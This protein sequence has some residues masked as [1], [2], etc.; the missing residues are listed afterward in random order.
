MD[1]LKTGRL[2]LFAAIG[3]F[4]AVLTTLFVP[5]VMVL[6]ALF[7]AVALVTG[8][9]S[10]RTRAAQIGL[11]ISLAALPG[12]AMVSTYYGRESRSSQGR[13]AAPAQRTLTVHFSPNGGC[14]EAIIAQIG[15]AKHSI[16]VQ[17]YSFTSTPI[18]TA[19]RAAHQRGIE[20]QVILDKS[21]QT[22]RYS[23]ATFL[24]NAGIAPQI[25]YDHAIAHNKIIVIDAAVVLTGSMNFSRVAEEK[26]A[27]NLLI[28]RDQE[29]A[30]RYRDN[31]QAHATHS[32]PYKPP[33]P[34]SRAS[35]QSP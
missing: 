29:L 23:S 7:E 27:E 30:A 13:T 20:V 3:G 12:V 35:V 18:A 2:S 19:L 21:Q 25:D 8:L 5:A 16:Y 17:A 33:A 10:L 9:M 11:L 1:N 4:L 32:R 34:F 31:W 15:Q 28:I 6:F 26:N 24:Y 14:T 22:D